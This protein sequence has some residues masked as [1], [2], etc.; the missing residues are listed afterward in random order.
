MKKNKKNAKTATFRYYPSTVNGVYGI[1]GIQGARG[2]QYLFEGVR[3]EDSIVAEKPPVIEDKEN[4]ED[5][6][7]SDPDIETDVAEV[8]NAVNQEA[9]ES[10]LPLWLTIV[11]VLG[12]LYILTKMFGGKAA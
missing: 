3:I 8:D 6:G 12:G 9:G 2:F 4:Q 7:S 1:E 11:F 10:G 5:N